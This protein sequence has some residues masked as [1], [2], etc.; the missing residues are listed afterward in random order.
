MEGA[1]SIVISCPACG[2]RF[3]FKQQPKKFRCPYCKPVPWEAVLLSLAVTPRPRLQ[4]EFMW[5]FGLA[6]A[7][8]NHESLSGASVAKRDNVI[9]RRRGRMIVNT[10]RIAANRWLIWGW[11]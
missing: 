5:E 11:L 7:I 3:R 9:V 8:A 2:K 4:S 10:R 6:D 1:M